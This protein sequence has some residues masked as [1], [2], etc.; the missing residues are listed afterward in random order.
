[1]CDFI[2]N[3]IQRKPK[4]RLGKNGIKEVIE[5]S[6]FNGYDWNAMKNKKNLRL[7]CLKMGIILIED[8]V[9]EMIK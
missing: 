6:W 4:N 8:I 2:N 5:H 7:M 3:L 9:W 1:M